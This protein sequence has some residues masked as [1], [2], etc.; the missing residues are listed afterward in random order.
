MHSTPTIPPR[1]LL[2]EGR[3]WGFGA[4]SVVPYLSLMLQSR[5]DAE[6]GMPESIRNPVFAQMDKALR[7][8]GQPH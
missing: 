3:R 7:T 1:P 2:P 6:Q 8:L 5:A 4:R